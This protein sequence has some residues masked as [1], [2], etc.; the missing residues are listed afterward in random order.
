[1]PLDPE[2]AGF[3]EA[4]KALPPRSSLD[5]AATRERLRQAAA[6]AGPSPVLPRIEN[7]IP[8]PIRPSRIICCIA[9]KVRRIAASSG[10]PHSSSGS[11][12]ATFRICP[13]PM[14]P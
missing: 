10:P 9:V 7:M 14:A 6:L 5:I 3:L 12:A 1:M 8:S 11:Y 4:Q 13:S 2:V